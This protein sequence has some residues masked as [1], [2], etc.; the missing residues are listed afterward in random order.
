MILCDVENKQ[1]LQFV[2]MNSTTTT[3]ATTTTTS[4]PIPISAIVLI[5]LGGY[6]II[7]LIAYL[8]QAFLRVFTFSIYL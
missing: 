3:T 8:I 6:L 1:F 2:N 4:L 5:I 7:A